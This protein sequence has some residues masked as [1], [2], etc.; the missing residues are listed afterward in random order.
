MKFQVENFRSVADSGWIETSD[1]TALIGTNESGK[2][3]LLMP[4]WKLNPA[5]KDGAVNLLA[6]APRNQY[7][8]IR[9]AEK[10]PIFIRAVLELEDAEADSVA[11]I[12]S[13]P[14]EDV[15][16]ASVDRDLD[17]NCFIGFP[18]D[19]PIRSTATSALRQILIAG[20]AEIDAMT[21]LGWVTGHSIESFTCCVPAAPVAG[22]VS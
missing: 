13:R 11:A 12:A 16:F 19:Q 8:V 15:R 14:R 18:N 3:N 6:D 21:A 22:D 4:L 10:K 17:G 1:V 7:N 9:D 5:G 2:T 20:R